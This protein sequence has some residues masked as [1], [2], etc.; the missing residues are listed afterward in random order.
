MNVTR[1]T[2]LAA[3][4]L[5]AIHF[6]QRP[7][8][9]SNVAKNDKDVDD[10]MSDVTTESTV[11]K[12]ETCPEQN[13]KKLV[14]KCGAH[15][16]PDSRKGDQGEDAWFIQDSAAGVFDGVGGWRKKGVDPGKYSRALRDGSVQY[17]KEHGV[18][19]LKLALKHAVEG[20]PNLGS[21][22]ACLAAMPQSPSLQVLNLGDSGLIQFRKEEI[23]FSTP[24][25][26]FRFNFPYQLGTNSLCTVDD[27]DAYVLEMQTGDTVVLATD[28][29]LDNLGKDEMESLARLTKDFHPNKAAEEFAKSANRNSLDSE[30]DSPFAQNARKVGKVY[31]GGKQDD[32]T[33]VLCRVC[34]QSESWLPWSRL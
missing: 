8:M 27:S 25:Q 20:N 34:E 23:K 2:A 33:V 7:G 26:Q 22:T 3:I 12:E 18:G 1:L 24:E 14:L 32:I 21:S 28:G 11:G 17:I 31:S 4:P 9:T 30:Y 13:R 19:D 6:Y 15:M 5:A 10:A 29:A 16:I